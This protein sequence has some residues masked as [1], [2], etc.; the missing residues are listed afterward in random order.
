MMKEILQEHG[1]HVTKQRIAI[2]ETLKKL[3]TPVTIESL[4]DA[5]DFQ[6]NQTTLYRSLALLVEKGIVYQADF[7]R[8]VAYYEFQGED[9][10]HHHLVCTSC[11]RSYELPFCPLG[12]LEEI[13]QEYQFSIT[14]HHFEIFGLCIDCQKL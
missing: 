4:R 1:V 5:L 11:G 3:G 8:G 12:A 7:R 6:I 10:H 13:S 2:L 9:N 14:S